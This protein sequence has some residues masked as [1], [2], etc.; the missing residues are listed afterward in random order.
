LGWRGAT[1]AWRRWDADRPESARRHWVVDQLP[2]FGIL[3]A[4]AAAVWWLYYPLALFDRTHLPGCG[5]GDVIQQAWILEWAKVGLAHHD[6]SFLTNRIDYPRGANLADSASF[7]LLAV[8]AAPLTAV[9]GPVATL[10]FLFRCGIWLTAASAFVT[11]R[12]LGMSVVAAGVAG[13]V[14]AFSPSLA[15]QASFHLFLVF[16]PLLP[17]LCALVYCQFV[18]GPAGWQRR[19]C[20]LG[21][22]GAAQFLIDNEVLLGVA[23]VI[24]VVIVVLACSR[25][26]Q[27]VAGKRAWR[28][29]VLDPALGAGKMFGLSA[30]IA[31]PIVAYPTWIAVAGP[32]H[33]VGPTQ[34]LRSSGINPLASVFPSYRG[35]LAWSVPGIHS[36][37]IV[38]QQN[39]AYIG[40]A[41]LAAILAVAWCLRRSALVRSA[42]LLTAAAWVFSLGG[43]R[44]VAGSW[45]GA[46]LPF[47]WLRSI[48]G[49]QDLIPSRLTIV[50]DLGVAVLLAL[51]VDHLVRRRR[52]DGSPIQRMAGSGTRIGVRGIAIAGI[53]IAVIGLLPTTRIHILKVDAAR[54]FTGRGWQP[55]LRGTVLAVPYPDFTNDAAMLWQADDGLRF[56][57]LGGYANRPLPNGTDTKSALL[58]APA[59]LAQVLLATDTARPISAH[60][61]DRARQ[62]LPGFLL[63]SRV[64]WIVT[65]AKDGP[66]CRAFVELLDQ[67]F[68]PPDHWGALRYW[69]SKGTR[70]HFV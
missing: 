68:G 15:H 70:A 66:G 45:Y 62:E 41:A 54:P 40:V 29:D 63:R 10:G 61:L 58:T 7:P 27:V 60:V 37:G 55:P 50:S 26:V 65:T 34:P 25:S 52:I 19:G 46:E 32:Q 14:F 47:G 43:G 9:A 18:N 16:V 53:A 59:A 56:A 64:N 5:C 24:A 3:L 11:A 51:A 12:R 22:I 36:Q 67:R 17:P 31:V 2:A 38:D 57:L 23:L 6:L 35:V 8:A 13:A 33:V 39:A 20:W 49:L 42:A 28:A 4:Y 44:S 1:G 69:S 30:L 21:A 48:P